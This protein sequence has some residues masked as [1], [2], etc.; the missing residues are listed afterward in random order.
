MRQAQNS[1]MTTLR[2]CDTHPQHCA[3]LPLDCFTSNC[4]FLVQRRCKNHPHLDGGDHEG[5]GICVRAGVAASQHAGSHVPEDEVLVREMAA[6]DRHLPCSIVSL[7]VCIVRRRI[8]A[9]GEVWLS[10]PFSRHK[11]VTFD[12]VCAC[13]LCV[14]SWPV[15]RTS[16]PFR[17]FV[18]VALVPAVL[19]FAHDPLPTLFH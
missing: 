15:F 10:R 6:V 8:V 9:L 16:F 14:H 12:V 7:H 5:G 19:T 1:C 3:A 2:G 4:T 18:A 17:L 13:Q 11:F